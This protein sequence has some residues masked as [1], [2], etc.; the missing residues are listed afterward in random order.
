MNLSN[1]SI[2][3]A[4]K[5]SEAIRDAEADGHWTPRGRTFLLGNGGSAAIASHICTDLIKSGHS[6][7][8]LTDPAVLTCFSNDYSYAEA[9]EAQLERHWN[10]TGTLIA[11]SSSGKSD[12]ILNAARYAKKA[13][14]NVITLSGF[15]DDNPLRS[16]GDVNYWV[17]ST[18]YGVVEIAHLAILHS[19]VNP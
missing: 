13:R 16:I 6:A 17:P 19:L 9:Y 4:R 15:K 8:T 10:Q 18:N 1:T 2:E 3:F 7:F 11:I 5:V 12:N 14:W